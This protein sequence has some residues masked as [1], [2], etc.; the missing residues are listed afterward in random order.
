[1]KE[2]SNQ[3]FVHS[4]KTRD[5]IK[6]GFGMSYQKNNAFLPVNNSEAKKTIHRPTVHNEERYDFLKGSKSGR[7]KLKDNFNAIGHNSIE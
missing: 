2:Y 5:I 7:K 3:T 1:M 6:N 4:I